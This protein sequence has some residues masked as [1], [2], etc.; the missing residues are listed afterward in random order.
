[1]GRSKLFSR[2]TD[3]KARVKRLLAVMVK[4]LYQKD[5][6]GLKARDMRWKE[7]LEQASELV[8]EESLARAQEIYSV[9]SQDAR[10]RIP[11]CGECK[12]WKRKPGQPNYGQCTHP[13][14]SMRLLTF[15]PYEVDRA[16]VEAM[17]KNNELYAYKGHGCY[18]G[19]RGKVIGK[20]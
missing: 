4:M 6:R 17:V 9:I 10:G 18:F 3:H 7:F 8:R 14:Q 13:E 15:N 5:V 19:V 12:Y 2:Q 16:K 11:R 1:M 20:L